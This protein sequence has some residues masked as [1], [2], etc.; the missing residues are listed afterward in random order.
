[1]ESALFY[2]KTANCKYLVIREVLIQSMYQIMMWEYS[3]ID[4]Q[5]NFL[6]LPKNGGVGQALPKL[7][8]GIDHFGLL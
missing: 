5:C 1:M 2:G 8:A 6:E 4:R 7:Q 3:L